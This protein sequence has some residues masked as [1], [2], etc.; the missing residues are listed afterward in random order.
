MN[1]KKFLTRLHL[2]IGVFIG[3]FIFLAAFSGA[4]YAFTFLAESWVYNDI[5]TSTGSG[6]TQS[7]EKQLE[8][9]GQVIGKSGELFSI[10]P[11][12]ENQ[13][14]TRILYLDKTLESSQ[15]RTLFINPYTLELK[16]NLITYGSS[17][18]MPA[19]MWVDLFHRDLL[20]G[21]LGRWYSELAASWMWI[22]GMTGIILFA[23]RKKKDKNH[24]QQLLNKHISLGL[25]SFVALVFLSITGLT[26]S[27]WAGDNISKIRNQFNWNTPSLVTKISNLHSQN[28]E[29]KT[30]DNVLSVA[31]K[32]GINSAFIEIKPPRKEI[33]SWQVSEIK[34]AYPAESDAVSVDPTNLNIIDHLKF[35]D[36]PLMAKLTRW[37]IDLHMGTLFGAFNQVV[38]GVLSLS[39]CLLIVTGYMLWVKSHGYK[40]KNTTF[41]E[42]QKLSLSERALVMMIFIPLFF[43]APL[44]FVSTLL[45]LFLEESFRFCRNI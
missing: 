10:R 30:F 45:I 21:K 13:Q 34:K 41:K 4:L 25:L 40:F 18:A 17:G 8:V 23:L 28:Y 12:L 42:F 9:G 16:A 38:I 24:Y 33:D 27:E 29:L 2:S 36:F 20:L 3:P 26:W 7:L 5:L 6:P 32:A 31:R 15:F 11:G 37:G 44:I 35:D 1:L 22:S 19:R 14:T 43:F 39:I